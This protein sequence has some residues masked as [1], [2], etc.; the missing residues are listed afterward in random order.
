MIRGLGIDLCAIARMESLLENDAFL[1]RYFAPEEAEYVL[2]RGAMA[3]ASLAGLYAAKEA[4]VKA[5]GEGFREIPLPDIVISH[6]EKGAPRYAPRGQALLALRERGIA[7]CHLS[8]THERE[9]AA[10]V[11]LLEG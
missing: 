10:A 7:H 5:L 8:I 2:G 1:K 6:T 3:A 4:F 11:C 9:M